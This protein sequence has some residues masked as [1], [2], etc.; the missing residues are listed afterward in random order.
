MAKR[1]A[2]LAKIRAKNKMAR[3][4]RSR[5][6][7]AKNNSRN[8]VK[9]KSIGEE[10]DEEDQWRRGEAERQCDENLAAIGSES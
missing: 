9:M 6:I 4:R 2:A 8:G 5:V 10:R 7:T 3:H 1:A